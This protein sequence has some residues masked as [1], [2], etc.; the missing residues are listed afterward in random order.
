MFE[1]TSRYYELPTA[2]YT[3]P[4]GA[5]GDPPG[6]ESRSVAY[7][8]RRFLPRSHGIEL[9]R[10]VVG[11]NERLDNITARFLGPPEQFWRVADANAAMN[12]FHLTDEIDR[13]L[14]ITMPQR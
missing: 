3:F 10:H 9:A 8:R 7:V 2:I 1:H 13:V 12:P 11:Q 14:R 4:E 5:P 6:D